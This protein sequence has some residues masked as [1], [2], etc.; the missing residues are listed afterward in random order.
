VNAAAHIFNRMFKLSKLS[1]ILNIWETSTSVKTFKPVGKILCLGVPLLFIFIGCQQTKEP[2][3]PPPPVAQKSRPVLNRVKNRGDQQNTSKENS[4]ADNFLSAATS[5]DLTAIQAALDT[6]ADPNTRDA[7]GRPA[8]QLATI[9]KHPAVVKALLEKGAD[10]ET[11]GT[12]AHA[13]H[14]TPVQLAASNGDNPTLQVLLDH[15]ANIDAQNADSKHTALFLAVQKNRTDTVKLLL[16]RGADANRRGARGY[17][18]LIQA[19]TKGQTAIAQLLL[20]HGANPDLAEDQSSW[21]ALMMAAV[22]ADAGTVEVLV[23]HGADI[24][25]TDPKGKTALD[26]AY[27]RNDTST[28]D[29]IKATPWPPVVLASKNTASESTGLVI[30]QPTSG[31]QESKEQQKPTTESLGQTAP[32]AEQN[33]ERITKLITRAQ[34][35]FQKK[36]LTTPKGDNTLDTCLEILALVPGQEVAVQLVRKMED[37]YRSWAD[38]T[39]N[40]KRRETYTEKAQELAA[41]AQ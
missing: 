38:T 5:G 26:V 31:E 15:G 27:Q 22:R 37:Q 23:N 33:H 10:P 32:A 41:I 30:V 17:T 40:K 14:F 21:T 16:E 13:P 3:P 34:K 18:P 2:E 7:Q 25:V 20:E 9:K 8:L 24:N 39:K 29:A 1:N 12:A 36:N 11:V 28:I 35:Q 4:A 6:G 19:A